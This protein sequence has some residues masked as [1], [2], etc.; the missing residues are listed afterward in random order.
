M[1]LDIQLVVLG[2][3]DKKYEDL[4][5]FMDY[6]YGDKMSANITFNAALANQIYAGSDFFLM[7]SKSEPCGLSQLISMRDGTVPIV[8]ETGGLVDTVPPVNT[9][10][11]EGN[12]FTFKTYNAHDMLGAVV[13]AVE[14]YHDGDKLE[15]FR[16]KIMDYDSS[17][18]K[19]AELYNGV[20]KELCGRE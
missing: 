1:E 20:Y 17:W 3:G 6:T 11:L 13:R 9:E 10:T 4:F 19:P 12:G 18:K 14:F 7:P 16:T 8:R 2:T 15:R 5:K